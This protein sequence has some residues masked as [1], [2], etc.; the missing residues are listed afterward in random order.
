MIYNVSNANKSSVSS[1]C[2]SSGMLNPTV[3]C[4][5]YFAVVVVVAITSPSGVA[6]MGGQ[7]L[8]RN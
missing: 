3:L 5:N 1:V 6:F 2:V 8:S 7:M 4:C